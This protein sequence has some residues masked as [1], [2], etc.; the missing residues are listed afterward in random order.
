MIQHRDTVYGAT[1][2]NRLAEAGD[3]TTAGARAVLESF[4]YA[5]GARDADALEAVWAPEPLVQLNNPLG[6]VL[7]GIE[8][9]TS[10]YGRVFEG[11]VRVEVRFQDVVEYAGPGH[12]VF[13]GREIGSYAH[14]DGTAVPLAI[15]TTRYLA[16]DAGAGR[17]G[18]LHHHGSIDDAPSLEAYQRAVRGG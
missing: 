6:G 9:V 18:Q 13:A 12:A 14:A 10:L 17:W 4:Y 8:A 5:L 11:P 16:Y 7:R 15:R 1:P 3:P 2:R